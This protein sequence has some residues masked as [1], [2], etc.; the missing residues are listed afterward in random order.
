VR[1][2]ACPVCGESRRERLFVKDDWPIA[3][4][5]A[6]S[7]VYVDAVLD[8]DALDALYGRDY[9]E[10]DTFAHYL[11]ERDVRVGSARGR[12]QHLSAIVPGGRLLDVGCAAGFFLE[13][14]AECY[15]VTGVEISAYASE[16]ARETLGHR[17]F[18]GEIFDAPLREGEFDVVTLW[19][20]VEH[21][22]D[23]RSVLAEI[24]RVTRPG[25][26][27]A[28]T[29]GNVEGPLARRDLEH[30]DLMFPPGHL[31]FFSPRTVERLL[32][33]AG[34]EIRRLVA[35][36]RVSARPRLTGRLPQLAAG[37]VGA[38][39]VMTVF[40][41]RT[42]RPRSRPVRARLPKAPS[43]APLT[44]RPADDAE[45]LEIARRDPHATFFHTPMWRRLALEG[46]GDC[47]DASFAAS[48]PSGVRAVFPLQELQPR[49]GR[50]RYL[51][52]TYPYGY[53]G[54][55]ADGVLGANDLRRLHRH[56][57]AAAVTV[58]GNPRRP[59]TPAVAGWSRTELS[60]QVLDLVPGYEELRR[61]F[62]KG[63]RAAITQARR[64]GVTTRRATS[65]DDYRAYH[66]V[67][68]DSLRRW[69]DDAGTRYPWTLFETGWRIAQEH[70]DAVGLWLAEHEGEVVSGAWVF[71]WN[72]HAMYWHAA[73][74][75][76]A[77]EL[78]PANLLLADVIED[79]CRC[80]FGQLD[81]GH[82]GGHKGA[83][84]FKRRFGAAPRPLVN[85][86]YVTPP[87]RATGALRHR[88]GRA[89]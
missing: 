83:E 37:T 30:W 62:S 57:Q 8:R 2:P 36:G 72:G 23:P 1:L 73:T 89:R 86:E 53:G 15:A 29:T 48:L 61:G 88:L 47:A 78:R 69:G 31:S 59:A 22:A 55:I 84:A 87:L 12:V 85:L 28:L 34:F 64:K 49:N 24:A 68:E 18:T 56:A 7:L 82:S 25:G 38:G 9:F 52:S 6:C 17:V 43:L 60:T 46:T 3:R 80:G 11:A 58:T 66:A 14:A 70:P 54:P 51:L 21:L 71:Y 39:N 76:R 45:W 67:Y 65:L 27:L 32:N 13:A 40:A 35:D 50:G 41:R 44:R 79:A 33:D 19:D 81:F 26:L 16:Y 4:C 5:P 77:F 75:E 20:V 74:L 10:G 63:H 42:S